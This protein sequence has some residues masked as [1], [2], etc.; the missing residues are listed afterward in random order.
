M[1]TT[2][3]VNFHI[4]PSGKYFQRRQATAFLLPSL[5]Y[6]FPTLVPNDL[7]PYR[8]T[9]T[10]PHY[11]SPTLGPSMRSLELKLA[12]WGLRLQQSKS[13]NLFSTYSMTSDAASQLLH[14]CCNL[15]QTLSF[16]IGAPSGITQGNECT[17]PSRNLRILLSSF[18]CL[19][20]SRASRHGSSS[21]LFNKT[22][23]M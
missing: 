18:E 13:C 8:G 23:L 20:L 19:S 6:S 12:D 9:V 16:V 7:C 2:D 22:K 11:M 5:T 1:T 3:R 10:H 14:D 4:W 17:T 15:L 21:K